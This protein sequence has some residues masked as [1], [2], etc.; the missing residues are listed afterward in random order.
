MR[1]IWQQM[2][3]LLPVAAIALLLSF[4]LPLASA[5]NGA[6]TTQTTTVNEDQNTTTKTT[7]VKAKP[8]TAKARDKSVLDADILESPLSY[9]KE[10]FT[11]DEE[12]KDNED[13]TATMVNTVKAL[14]ATLLSTVI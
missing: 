7:K 2:R 1:N 14:V 4:S 5:H 13:N 10:A 11:P 9:F 12:D 6:V 3:V 8:A